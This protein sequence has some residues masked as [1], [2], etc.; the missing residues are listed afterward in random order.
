MISTDLYVTGAAGAAPTPAAVVRPSQRGGDVLHAP[1]AAPFQGSGLP[2]AV[3][4]WAA[5]FEAGSAL[6]TRDLVVGDAAGLAG[7]AEHTPS[8]TPGAPPRGTT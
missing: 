1:T 3:R 5:A 7:Y 2:A 6:R 8:D 4:P